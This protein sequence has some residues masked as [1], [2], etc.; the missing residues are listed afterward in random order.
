MPSSKRENQHGKGAREFFKAASASQS[1]WHKGP[2]SQK[3]IFP[4]TGVGGWFG[5]DSR[6]FIPA[7]LLLCSTVPN[8]PERYG[9][10][11]RTLGTPALR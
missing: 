5:D 10:A 2:V 9:S 1:L 4:Q 11:A 3:T 7:H 6:A 8:R